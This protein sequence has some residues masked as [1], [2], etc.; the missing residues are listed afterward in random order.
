M[1][2]DARRRDRRRVDRRRRLAADHETPNGS[3][4]RI[5]TTWFDP[6]SDALR[7]ALDD[8][9]SARHFVNVRTTHGGPSPKETG[10]AIA[11]SQQNLHDDRDNWQAR[12][13]R[14]ARAYQE[15]FAALAK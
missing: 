9:L 11:E 1:L 7:E 4:E 6:R 3:N 2:P 5:R 14:I 12:R 10:R 13:E 15:S 8:L